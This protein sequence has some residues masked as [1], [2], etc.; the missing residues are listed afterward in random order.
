[1]KT[2]SWKETQHQRIRRET[3]EFLARGGQI[4]RIPA[5]ESGMRPDGPRHHQSFSGAPRSERT[6]LPEVVAAIESRKKASQKKQATQ[7][8]PTKRP[9]RKLIYDDFGEPLRWV[10]DNNER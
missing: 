7:R 1:M 2:P 6:P 10:W 9:S 8:R 5:G 4:R 3:R